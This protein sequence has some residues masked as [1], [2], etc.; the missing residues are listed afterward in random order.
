MVEAGGVEPLNNQENQPQ[1]PQ[2]DS[3][4][5]LICPQENHSDLNELISIWPTLTD[6]VKRV[7]LLFA[8][9]GGQD[10]E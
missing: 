9:E 10:N 4:C 5:P 3:K 8:R 6:K 1:N 2:N 7:L